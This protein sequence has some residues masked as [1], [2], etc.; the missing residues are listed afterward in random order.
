MLGPLEIIDTFGL[1]NARVD[2]SEITSSCPYD[3][4][5]KRGDRRPS[6][7]IDWQRGL[8]NCLGCGE[9][10]NLVKL[11]Q[12]ILGMSSFEA[13]NLVYADMTPEDALRL[14]RGGAVHTGEGAQTARRTPEEAEIDAWCAG[15]RSYWYARGFNDATIGKWRLGYDPASRRAVVP[16]YMRGRLL[17]WTKRTVDDAVSP[18]W[19]HSPDL[20][21]NAILFGMDNFSGDEAVLV[22]AP[23]SAIMLDQYGVGNAVASFGASLSNEQAVLLRSNYNKVTLFYDPDAAGEKGTENAIAKLADY[24]EV[25]VVPKT[26]DDPAAMTRDECIEALEGGGVLPAWAWKMGRR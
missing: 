24:M 18:K 4:N 3:A 13:H 26:R 11:A 1:R 16:V 2:G 10:G 6:F 23:L 20:Q 22:E 21:R 12:D 25:A 9:S 15:D 17:G 14:M 19:Q 5:H 8:Y 7:G